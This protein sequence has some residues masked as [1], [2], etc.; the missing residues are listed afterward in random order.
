MRKFVVLFSSVLAGASLFGAA[1][2]RA[3]SQL[4]SNPTYAQIM[5][6]TAAVKGEPI[7]H[8]PWSDGS[9]PA[10]R[11]YSTPTYAQVE[12]LIQAVQEGGSVLTVPVNTN[13]VEHIGELNEYIHD[14]GEL[15]ATSLG[16][17]LLAILGALAFLKKNAL[18]GGITEGR[19]DDQKV[20]ELFAALAVSPNALKDKTYD[21][22]DPESLITFYKDVA[23]VLGVK[24]AEPVDE[25]TGSAL[26]GKYGVVV[27]DATTY[28]ELETKASLSDT[29]PLRKLIK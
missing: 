19:P 20:G 21:F 25:M 1:D 7:D 8:G 6:L 27:T 5:R 16:G 3:A 4:Y 24:A 15:G 23:A 29:D 10:S 2:P 17:L 13:L 28:G 12:K 26:A 14:Y 22:T 11:L 9:I 18:T